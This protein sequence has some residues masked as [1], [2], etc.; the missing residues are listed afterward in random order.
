VV[1]RA[2]SWG[3]VAARL[4]REVARAARPPTCAVGTTFVRHPCRQQG[5]RRCGPTSS[6]ASPVLRSAV[7]ASDGRRVGRA[8]AWRG[9]V[10][11]FLVP[12]GRARMGHT[13]RS[14][15]GEVRAVWL[16]ARVQLRG[17]VPVTA[18]LALLVGGSDSITAFRGGSDIR[19]SAIS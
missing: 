19:S 17:R 16:R 7:T 4:L 9:M 5:H 11:S 6:G 18:L 10:A 15:A 1:A 8:P 2:G 14:K 12:V 13:L 3:R